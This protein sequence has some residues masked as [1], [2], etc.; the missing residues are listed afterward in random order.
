MSTPR[1][2]AFQFNLLVV[3]V[4]TAVAVHL[5]HLPTWM[6]LSMLVLLS[7]RW[8][9]RS[10]RPSLGAFPWWLR[11]P[12]ALALLLGVIA[13]YGNV[14]G[15]DPGSA[16][17]SGMLIMKLCESERSRDAKSAI[18]F[19]CFLLMAALLFDQGLIGTVAVGL[20]LG[21]QFAALRALQRE[22][23]S[24]DDVGAARGEL[25]A[26]AR[27]LIAALPIAAAAFLLLPRLSTPL[28]GQ[29]NTQ[30]DR[31]GVG[32]EMSPG[33]LGEL[34]VDDSPAFRVEFDGTLPKTAQQYWRG[35]VLWHY[36]GQ[37]W[38][39]QSQA[40]YGEG[41]ER[42]LE[43]P[44]GKVSYTVTLEPTQQRKLFA[45]DMPLAAPQDSF[46]NLDM[47]VTA[48]RPVSE[49]RRYSV[50]SALDYRLVGLTPQRRNMAL[51]LPP[52]YN[53]RTLAL[54][55]EWRARASSDMDVVRSAFA[56]FNRSFTYTLTPPQL[57]RDAM[58]DFLF[59]TR[60]GYCEHY[61]SAFTVLM[62]AAGIPARV[63]IGYQGGFWNEIGDYMIVRQSDAHAWS[64]VWLDDRGWVRLD[65]TGAVNE[66]RV[67]QGAQSANGADKPWYGAGW[68][69]A[70][71]NRWDVVNHFWNDAIVRFDT[72]RQS[73][74]LKPLGVDKAEAGD[75]VLALLVVGIAFMLGALWW[76]LRRERA[77]GDALDQAFSRL[78]ALLARHGLVREPSE[79]PQNY[80]QR[81]RTALGPA[82]S[83]L[84]ALFDTYIGLRYGCHA[85]DSAD[86]ER[87]SRAV[88][89][90]SRN[91]N[92][93]SRA[94]TRFVD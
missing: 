24:P 70:L 3:A 90:F 23:P 6:N 35:K 32:D 87:F 17:A 25:A 65:P 28:W 73:N 92:L 77:P 53:P 26:A 83:Q 78:A 85:A 20:C 62:R 61:A 58:D 14:F 16:L 72:L 55:R 76:A 47:V 8:L 71:R 36:D 59:E 39:G 15:R 9:Q 74:L 64:E 63:V 75:L 12:L 19:A 41:G 5:S 69:V 80:A 79:G 34:L 13:H 1:L 67:Q 51:L 86:V 57:G 7:V 21:P 45:L 91:T 66:A 37:T 22:E 40:G 68:L 93:R 54:A 31:T 29:P 81:A 44:G 84:D 50:Q 49:L 38:R 33:S 2:D 42:P 48:N 18:T 88:A 43:K 4:G 56:L 52:G 46:L 60:A 30:Q 89:D 82:A 10:S 94:P 11:L 27:M